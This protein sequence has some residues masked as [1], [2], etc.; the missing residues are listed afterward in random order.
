M[1]HSKEQI[2][3]RFQRLPSVVQDIVLS[4]E[5]EEVIKNISSKHS[6][7]V[8]T[9]GLL[10]EEITYVMVG[11]EKATDFIRN[12]KAQTNLPDEKIN[13][14]AKDVNEKI[15][16]PIRKSL[17]KAGDVSPAESGIRNQESRKPQPQKEIHHPSLNEKPHLETKFPSE[18]EARP[19]SESEDIKKQIKQQQEVKKVTVP[20]TNLPTEPHLETKFP[21]GEEKRPTH[22]DPYREPIE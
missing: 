4:S 2:N 15:F 11:A 5:T 1:R 9:A 20:P 7:H 12:L 22:V 17:K 6:L 3:E 19:L 10:S 8:D 21:S 16:L 14:I 18:G 13:A